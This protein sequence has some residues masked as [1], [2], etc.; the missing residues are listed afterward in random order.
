MLKF[1]PVSRRYLLS[2][3]SHTMLLPPSMHI[4]PLCEYATVTR[5]LPTDVS[6]RSWQQIRFAAWF[7]CECYTLPVFFSPVL[8]PSYGVA[9]MI[10]KITLPLCSVQYILL[11]NPTLS[12]SLLHESFHLA[13]CHIS[14]T[15]VFASGFLSYL[16]Y[17]SLCIWLSVISL[18][19]ESLHL[20]FCHISF[21]RVFASGFLSYLFYTSL[22]I[23]VS[24][25]SLLHKS[26]HLVACLP[27]RL[28]P[29]PGASNITLCFCRL[30]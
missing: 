1:R 15:R 6:S 5:C 11:L 29:G 20:A 26:F 8:F 27:V 21:T 25:I 14:F 30:C 28:F 4:R 3:P 17:T 24:V 13:F 2:R 23:R 12:T 22:C 7:R 10:M 19:H 18:L 16:F 9:G